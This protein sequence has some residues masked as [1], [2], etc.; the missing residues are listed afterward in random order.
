MQY[1][2]FKNAL[3]GRLRQN[4]KMFAG[5]CFLDLRADT[6]GLGRIVVRQAGAPGWEKTG[7]TTTS[8]AQAKEWVASKA[9]VDALWRKHQLRQHR[10]MLAGISTR[11]AAERYLGSLVETI[12]DS[13]GVHHEVVPPHL[14][15]RVSMIRCHVVPHLGHIALDALVRAIVRE[16]IMSLVVHKSLTP[17]GPRKKVPASRGTQLQF[18]RALLA[19][20]NFIYP[21]TPA[22]FSGI[23]IAAPKVSHRGKLARAAQLALHGPREHASNGALDYPQLETLLAAAMQ[24]DME[25]GGRANLSGLFVPETVYM[26]VLQVALGVRV[27]ELLTL[28]WGHVHEEEGYVLILNAKVEQLE[29]REERAVPLPDALRAWLRELRALRGDPAP[30]ELIIRTGAEPSA[31][32]RAPHL[33]DE[34]RQRAA[35]NTVIARFSRVLRR[36]GMKVRGKASH[37]ARST[38]FSL[39]AGSEAVDTELLKG[40]MGHKVIFEGSSD[41]YFRLLVSSIKPQHRAAL[42]LPTPEAVRRAAERFVPRADWKLPKKKEDRSR[43]GRAAARSRRLERTRLGVSLRPPEE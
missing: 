41:E 8:L 18:K 19:I 37:G 7:S 28:M 12:T 26:L 31:S 34:D 4:A 9:F 17:G 21:D 27:S 42:K 29:G 36:A 35:R 22:P 33:E 25:M 16:A 32:S 23:K 3:P 30:D 10:P 38:Y 40:F 2:T 20:W 1:D 24:Y 11:A 15:S 6:F 14:A 5:A 43:A 39:M 13:N